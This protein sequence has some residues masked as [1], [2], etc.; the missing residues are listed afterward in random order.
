[1]SSRFITLAVSPFLAIVAPSLIV[2]D[3][4]TNLAHV[5]GMSFGRR[6]YRGRR[7]RSPRVRNNLRLVLGR[8]GDLLARQRV[9][10]ACAGEGAVVY[11]TRASI[12]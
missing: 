2:G 8:T 7:N 11:R 5:R 1:V 12:L 4:G 10:L 3:L 9:V 6:P